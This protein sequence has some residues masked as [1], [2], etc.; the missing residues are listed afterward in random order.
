[1]AVLDRCFIPTLPVYGPAVKV[2]TAITQANP[3]VVTTNTNHNYVTGTIVRLDIPYADGM[4]QANLQFG[5]I[6]V[7]SPTTFAID[8]DSTF[9][10]AFSIPVA[11]PPTTQICALTVPIGEDN[12]ILTAAVK[13]VLR[14]IIV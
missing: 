3:A 13:N 2:I 9:Y 14:S 7:L 10:D 4:Q 6:V 11:P 1:M 8:L 5:T 12:G